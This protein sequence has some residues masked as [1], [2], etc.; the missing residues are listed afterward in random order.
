MFPFF[1]GL[2]A[3]PYHRRKQIGNQG[4][5]FKAS[6]KGLFDKKPRRRYNEN[7]G[8]KKG[9]FLKLYFYADETNPG[10]KAAKE[11]LKKRY[12]A[13][14]APLKNAD[15]IISLGGDGT[16]LAALRLGLKYG[17]KVYGMNLGHLGAYQNEYSPVDLPDRLEKAEAITL[18]PLKVRALGE[19][20]AVVRQ[21]AWNEVYV[22]SGDN[23]QQARLIGSIEGDRQPF[24]VCGDGHLLATPMGSAAYNVSAGGYKLGFRERLL[25]ST[26]IAACRGVTDILPAAAH[27]RLEAVQAAKR[28]VSL[29]ADN[30]Y[31]GKVHSC[32]IFHDFSVGVPLLWD[33]KKVEHFEQTAVQII[34]K[35]PRRVQSSLT[36]KGY[37]RHAY[38][39]S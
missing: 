39:R 24:F 5:F 22:R 23:P 12:A 28:S 35:R 10:A 16:T 4:V 38:Q 14:V 6:D 15:V 8:K 31:L 34:A 21:I 9:F 27:V 29:F 20:G 36:L 33:E 7:T 25:A 37:Y 32:D 3:C 1:H 11:A 26:S 18:H 17:K 13:I 2:F 19:Q 30:L